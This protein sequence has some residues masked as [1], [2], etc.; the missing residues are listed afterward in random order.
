MSAITPDGHERDPVRHVRVPEDLWS[1]AQA[2]V[3]ARGDP[4]LSF[5]IRH[6]ISEYVDEV[7][8]EIKATRGGRRARHARRPPPVGPPRPGE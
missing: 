7:N 5:V 3:L 1:S 8:R 6:A 4:S 2:A